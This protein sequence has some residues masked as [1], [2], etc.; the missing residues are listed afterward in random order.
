MARSSGF[1]P[2]PSTTSCIATKSPRGSFHRRH[3]V[4]GTRVSQ[5]ISPAPG[6]LLVSLYPSPTAIPQKL[7]SPLIALTRP[8]VIQEDTFDRPAG[9][10]SAISLPR[11][12]PRK[13]LGGLAHS[14][15]R[16]HIQSTQADIGCG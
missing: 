11:P 2:S 4:W 8:L 7:T 16:K 12:Q 15:S 1:H 3:R 5:A 9:A 6:Y 13:A 10:M 14:Q